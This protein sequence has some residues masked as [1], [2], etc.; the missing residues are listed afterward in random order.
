MAQPFKTISLEERLRNSRYNELP[1]KPQSVQQGEAGTLSKQQPVNQGTVQINTEQSVVDQGST[2]IQTTINSVEQ[3]STNIQTTINSVEQGSIELKNITRTINQGT[4][5]LDSN[6][7]PVNQGSIEIKYPTTPE[8]LQTIQLKL[9]PDAREKNS[10]ILKGYAGGRLQPTLPVVGLFTTTPLSNLAVPFA[11]T[12]FRTS[13]SLA[14]RLAQPNLGTT[15]H[16]PQV[17]LADLFTDYI[18]ITPFGIFNH[19]SDVILQIPG[20]TPNQGGLNPIPFTFNP[21]FVSPVEPL[22]PLDDFT[23]RQGTVFSNGQYY[24]LVDILY[25]TNEIILQQGVFISSGVLTSVVTPTISVAPDSIVQGPAVTPTL[26]IEIESIAL[27]QALVIDPAGNLI[28]AYEPEIPVAIPI[29]VPA[30]IIIETPVVSLEQGGT[31]PTPFTF[32]PE[33][34]APILEVLGYA[35]DRALAFFTPEIKHGSGVLRGTNFAAT[36]LPNQGEVTLQPVPDAP[37]QGE[38]TLGVGP[39]TPLTSTELGTKTDSISFPLAQSEAGFGSL[40]SYKALSYNQIAERGRQGSE[41]RPDFRIT[42][43]I[44]VQ[45]GTNVNNRAA[46]A[47]AS[48][49]FVTLQIDSTTGQGSVKFVSYITTFNDSFNIGWNDLNYV[50]RQ[51]TLKTFKGV[52]RAGSIAFKVAA[53]RRQDLAVIYSKLNNLIKIAGVG[54][55]TSANDTYITGPLC[56]ITVGNWFNKTPCIFNSIKYDVQMADYSWDISQEMPHLVD[57]SLDF[58]LLGDRSGNPLNATSNDYFNYIG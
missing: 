4:I 14:D 46:N 26:P 48:N 49:D 10:V 16:L 27:A 6:I 29:V 30:S 50:G 25:P 20:A 57:V 9:T 53:M 19:T 21:N 44:P 34:Q 58:A 55:A 31:D 7:E 2:N 56:Q 1:Q 40:S 15:K 52:T 11:N 12:K 41:Q 3:G 37:N 54:K 23:I 51:D 45:G 35:A 47:N 8:E 39:S 13:I 24:S 28:S 5:E 32:T 43:G 36:F 17:F 33:I 22:I 42:L 18:T 38:I